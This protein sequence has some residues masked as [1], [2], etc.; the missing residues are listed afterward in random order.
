MWNCVLIAGITLCLIRE[1]DYFL[2]GSMIAWFVVFI[3][4]KAYITYKKGQS[5]SE[6]QKV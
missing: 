3:S 1:T 2:I 6:E 4:I 5:I